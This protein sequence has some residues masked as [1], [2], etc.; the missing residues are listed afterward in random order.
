MTRS[1]FEFSKS[2]T[3]YTIFRRELS[4]KH[5]LDKAFDNDVSD[6]KLR[7]VPFL[8]IVA[9]SYPF[10]TVMIAFVDHIFF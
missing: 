4:D 7:R 5:K 2:E 10:I 6:V 8:Q 9:N 3:V 1:F